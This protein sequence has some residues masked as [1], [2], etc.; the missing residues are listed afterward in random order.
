MYTGYMDYEC[1]LCDVEGY[2]KYSV[3][4]EYVPGTYDRP[5]EFPQVELEE[6]VLSCDCDQE[7]VEEIAYK[8]SELLEK[9]YDHAQ[10]EIERLKGEDEE[11]RAES[12]RIGGSLYE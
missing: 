2:V 10:E 8:S 6:V 3:S 12:K 9:I 11:N 5:A 1:P 4:G 7:E